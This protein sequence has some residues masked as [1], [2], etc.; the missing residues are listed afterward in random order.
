MGH[1]SP[2]DDRLLSAGLNLANDA[3]TGA[4]V[5]GL[6]N[7][8]LRS[9]VLKGPATRSWLYEEGSGRISEDIDLLIRRSDLAAMEAE[10]PRLGFN[11]VG[12]SAVGDGRPVRHHWRHVQ[13]SVLLELHTS[14]TG[15]GVSDDESW[16]ILTS[17]TDEMRIGPDRVEVLG[18]AARTMH[19]A[20]HAAQHG[21]SYHRTQADL[22]R[23]LQLV[24]EGAWKEAARLA[25]RLESVAAFSAGLMLL[26]AGRDLIRRLDLQPTADIGVALRAET[27]PPAAQG[28]AWMLSLEGR[29]A[30]VRFLLRA[31]APPRVYMRAWLPLANHGRAGLALAYLWRPAWL[32]WNALPAAL[33]WRRARR[34]TQDE[35]GPAP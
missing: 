12:V 13:S 17:A 10:L 23:A 34:R 18:V 14:L 35:F 30:Q 24:P 33:A 25:K 22:S 5:E 4:L 8:G 21:R 16:R 6:R 2:P 11:H 7:A 27:A 19:I 32:A 29:R 26:P 3:V 15:I 9:V 31:L 28:L 20:L 1:G